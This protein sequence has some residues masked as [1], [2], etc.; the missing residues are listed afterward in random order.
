MR[1][2]QFVFTPVHKMTITIAEPDDI[3]SDAMRVAAD[4]R[5]VGKTFDEYMGS[6]STPLLKIM[7]MMSSNR[8]VGRARPHFSLKLFC[9]ICVPGSSMTVVLSLYSDPV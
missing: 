7:G 6:L 9:Q 2:A 5:S 3:V 4:K 8:Y 1:T